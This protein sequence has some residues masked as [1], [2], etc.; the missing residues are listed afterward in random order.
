[1]F[2]YFMFIFAA[3]HATP[4]TYKRKNTETALDNKPC[5]PQCYQHLVS[6]SA[7]RLQ[8]YLRSLTFELGEVSKVSRNTVVP[9]LL[10]A[11]Q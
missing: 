10:L 2:V 5:G 9:M 3:F 1:M 6:L 4:N 11:L 8:R 7:V